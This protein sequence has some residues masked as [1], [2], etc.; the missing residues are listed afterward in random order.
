LY[1]GKPGG[2]LFTEHT[3]FSI[4]AIFLFQADSVLVKN[5]VL[6]INYGGPFVTL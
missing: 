2:K 1:C 6:E 4:C 3:S 5:D